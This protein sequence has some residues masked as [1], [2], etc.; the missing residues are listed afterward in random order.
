MSTQR[1]SGFFLV[2]QLQ[3][4]R[5][6][7]GL[8]RWTALTPIFALK[9]NKQ[10]PSSSPFSPF[11]V[12]T[13][14]PSPPC[15]C[16]PQ[17]RLLLTHSYAMW[18]PPDRLP[19]RQP[20]TQKQH[21]G[22][23]HWHPWLQ[24]TG[25]IQAGF[26]PRSNSP[27]HRQLFH[28]LSTVSGVFSRLNTSTLSISSFHTRLIF[29]NPAL[30]DLPVSQANLKPNLILPL[31]H[32]QI[33]LL[34][35]PKVLWSLAASHHTHHSHCGHTQPYTPMAVLLCWGP[36]YGLLKNSDLLKTEVTTSLV[37][38]FAFESNLNLFL[39]SPKF[40][41]GSFSS[42]PVC[43][44]SCCASHRAPLLFPPQYPDHVPSAYH[45]VPNFPGEPFS[46]SHEASHTH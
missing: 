27:S 25:L 36:L 3:G 9:T 16:F 13:P 34:L 44:F 24:Q 19:G 7:V 45:N 17:G 39:F 20:L 35:T 31:G 42:Q 32:Q 14:V 29:K 8:R 38:C 30:K 2:K 33:L 23:H 26:A 12:S 22:Q 15:H 5:P 46:S 40:H 37:R 1:H 4:L 10:P 18:V 41:S 6:Q 11:S 28:L 21:H 43:S